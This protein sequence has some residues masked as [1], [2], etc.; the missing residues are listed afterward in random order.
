[1]EKY[2]KQGIPYYLSTFAQDK[3]K[4]KMTVN[5][6]YVIVPQKIIR[7]FRLNDIEKVLLIEILSYMGANDYAFPSHKRLAFKLGK[8]STASIKN[9]LKSLKEKGFIDWRKG[10]GDIGSNRYTLCDLYSNP[11][12]I[13]SEFTHF[14]VEEILHDYRDEISYEDIYSTVLEIAEKPKGAEV[15]NDPYGICIDWLFKDRNL[16]DQIDMYWLFGDILRC[17]MEEC[18]GS[19][20]KIEGFKL[21]LGYFQQYHPAV[22]IDYT[23]DHPIHKD[24]KSPSDEKTFIV[25]VEG[26]DDVTLR[27]LSKYHDEIGSYLDTLNE[28]QLYEIFIE[29]IVL[30]CPSAVLETSQRYS[31]F[32][33]AEDI[34]DRINL[35]KGLYPPYMLKVMINVYYTDLKRSDIEAT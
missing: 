11:Y 30:D 2:E 35:V 5:R 9:A 34:E 26:M 28:K 6:G 10:G 19:L 13:M 7:C 25:S 15:T 20:I 27:V 24:L 31:A 23:E 18:S 21:A 29:K 16:R 32:M 22:S 4:I 3:E 12:L 14:F 1:M 17:K 8:K 33:N